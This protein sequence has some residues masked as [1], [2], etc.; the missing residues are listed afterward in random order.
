MGGDKKEINAELKWPTIAASK[1]K[2]L[3]KKGENHL[4]TTS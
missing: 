4:E 3:D 1:E 2:K